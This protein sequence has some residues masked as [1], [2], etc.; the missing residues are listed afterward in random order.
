M[1]ARRLLDPGL[2]GVVALGFGAVVLL[3]LTGGGYDVI[4]RGQLAILIWWVLLLGVLSGLL[5]LRTPGRLAVVAILVFALYVA[6]TGLS[7]TWTE[8]SERTLTDLSRVAAY[9]GVFT[10]AVALRSSRGV[11][12]T[13]AA[14]GTGIVIVACVALASRLVP[15]LFPEA[16]E[17]ARLLPREGYRLGFPLDYWN[18]L[19]A[20]I[21]V[22]LP[23]V[24][25]VAGSA[26]LLILRS[27]AAAVLP[28]MALT[29]FLTFSRSGVGAAAIAI[30]VYL[31]FCP[32]RLPR[33]ATLGIAG[34]GSALLVIL[35]DGSEFVSQGPISVTGATGEGTDL[36]LVLLAVCVTV[37]LLQAAASRGFERWSRPRWASPSRKTSVR[38]LL[39]GAAILL[40]AA[41][42]LGV[43]E[44]ADNAWKEFKSPVSVVEEGSSRFQS[45]G[46]NNRYQF[47]EAAVEQNSTRPLV[48]RGSGT[49]EFWTNRSTKTAGFV[50]DAH[51]L[52]LE[53]LGELGIV[54]AL[55]LIL[56][57][58]VVL[59]GGISRT[60]G[61]S[62]SRRSQM[63]A[64]L[65]GCSAF[66]VVAAVDWTWELGVVAVTFLLLASVLVTSGDS[67]GPRASKH[68]AWGARSAVTIVAVSAIVAISIPLAS[69]SLVRES[70]QAA[71]SGDFQMALN[72]AFDA[73]AAEPSA[74]TPLLQQALIFEASG[75]PRVG[76]GPA[77]AATVKEP[78][79]WRTWLIRFRLEAASGDIE[80]AIRSFRRA[81][82]L[83]PNSPIFGISRGD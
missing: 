61:A 72:L 12:R 58:S 50:R 13:V 67:V 11:S 81:R 21:A 4:V 43:P 3:A 9:L 64:A 48:G 25:H 77:R 49:F 17:T 47:W 42:A 30:L 31:A 22:G 82:V 57:F 10:L 20:L 32:D 5:P 68:T 76:V 41:L 69:T 55:I 26:R 44:K 78:T 2:L 59:V 74:A 23:L 39:A 27:L 62:R 83:N 28:L 15:D 1:T 60:L 80:A 33:L 66:V 24:F 36:L 53:T 54:G 6:W 56:F 70:Q 14:V 38:T 40:V 35:A 18:G 71:E 75:K 8:S 37:G 63:A 29:L 45:F 73:G 79:N 65:A 46:G 19:G 16:T 52:Y 51:S 7:L 34:A